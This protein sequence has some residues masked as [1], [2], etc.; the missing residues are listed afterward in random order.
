MTK[1]RGERPKRTNL[2]KKGCILANGAKTIES[3]WQRRPGMAAGAGSLLA[4]LYLHT[5][6]R[7]SEQDMAKVYKPSESS[8]SALLLPTRLYLLTVP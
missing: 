7:E 6:N 5:G 2:R 4:V 8:P 1:G 3:S